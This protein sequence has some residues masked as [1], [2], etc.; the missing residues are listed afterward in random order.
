ML[1]RR[2]DFSCPGSDNV[3]EVAR[4]PSRTAILT[5]VAR[6]LCG[7][8]PG[9]AVFVDDL[10]M[11]LA[12]D[13]GRRLLQRLRREIPRRHLGAFIRWVCIRSRFTEDL[14]E[15]AIARGVGQYVILGAGLDSFAHRR[16]ELVDRLRVFEVDHPASQSWK[17]SRLGVLGVKAPANLVFAPVDFEHQTLREGLS[18]AGF[19]FRRPA[20]VSWIGVTMY[21]TLDAIGSTLTTVAQSA[22]G[23]RI[24]LTYNRPPDSLDPFSRE[25]TGA[26]A[27]IAAE[28]GEPFLSLF[29]PDEIEEL[30]RTHGFADI[31]HFGSQEARAAYF[32]ADPDV[33]IAGAQR[34]VVATSP[35]VRRG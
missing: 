22:P 9:P 6:A 25:V 31:V 19:E 12:G 4:P 14:V 23:T 33:E 5:A 27:A 29:R 15:D 11:R 1:V 26:L 28:M 35:A 8:D 18:D 21:L 32:K 30:L 20:L 3:G 34:L 10:A 13:E 17:R 16:G 7:E 24:V 2:R